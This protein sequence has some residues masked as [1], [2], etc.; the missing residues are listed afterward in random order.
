MLVSF[1]QQFEYFMNFVL[2]S[3]LSTPS[4]KMYVKLKFYEVT[5]V[6]LKYLSEDYKPG[7]VCIF[8]LMVECRPSNIGKIFLANL[9]MLH[10]KMT[11]L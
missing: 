8:L 3:S 9:K 11:I 2:L 10:C 5:M 7:S 6:C 4:C 1:S